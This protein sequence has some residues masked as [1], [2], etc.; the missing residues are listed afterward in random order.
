MMQFVA[1]HKAGARACEAW[2]LVTRIY[3]GTEG[4]AALRDM[5]WH[6]P[7]S[8]VPLYR[9]IVQWKMSSEEPVQL[10]LCLCRDDT[11]QWQLVYAFPLEDA[12]ATRHLLKSTAECV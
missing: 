1:R 8:F 2:Q 7:Q 3:V 12:E 11:G 5:L 4:Y 6:F 9:E 10:L